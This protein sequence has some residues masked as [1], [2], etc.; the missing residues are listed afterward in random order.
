[1]KKIHPAKLLLLLGG[2]CASQLLSGQSVFSVDLGAIRQVENELN[3]V[4]VSGFYHLTEK[5]KIG[6]EVNRFFPVTRQ[7][8][9]GDFRLSAWDLDLNLQYLVPLNKSR[10]LRFYPIT[11]ISHSAEKESDLAKSETRTERF[12][13]VNTGTGILWQRGKLGT[14]VEYLLTW[15]HQNQ[16][17]LLAGINIEFEPGRH[18]EKGKA[19]HRD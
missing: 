3:G 10:S 11:G 12:W 6:L 14:H 7:K 13:S 4:N 2:I 19:P 9:G 8:V 16:Q 1:M 17:F 15:G 18:H 5:V